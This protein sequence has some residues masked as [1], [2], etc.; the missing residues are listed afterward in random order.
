[1]KFKIDLLW[2]PKQTCYGGQNRPA[3]EAKKDLPWSLKETYYDILWRPKET[4][5][6]V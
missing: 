3:M 5:H 1:M 6:G 4:Y 2:R